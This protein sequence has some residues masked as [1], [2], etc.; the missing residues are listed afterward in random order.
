VSRFFRMPL[1]GYFAFLLARDR[2]HLWQAR[3]ALGGSP[4]GL[5]TAL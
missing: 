2:R 3:R 1:G 5:P 4:S